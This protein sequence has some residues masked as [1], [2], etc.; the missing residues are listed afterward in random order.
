MSDASNTPAPVV[1]VAGSDFNIDTLPR[2][3]LVSLVRKGLAHYLGNEQASKVTAWKASNPDAT[4]E[5]I[6]TRK[7]EF[8]AAAVEA[9]LA[10]TMGVQSTRGPRA[11]PVDAVARRMAEAEMRATLGKRNPPIAMPKGEAVI[12][13]NT[14]DGTAHTF[15]R[16]QLIE[17][18][19]A[20]PVHGPRLRKAAEKEVAALAKVGAGDADGLDA[21]DL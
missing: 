4:D 9:I 19:L 10:G 1:T 3:S 14:P 20:H 6:A 11:T 18:R 2:Q 17:R 13:L 21:L 8:V 15:T 12:T 7:S 5:A 16:V